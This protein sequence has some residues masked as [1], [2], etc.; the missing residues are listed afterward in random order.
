MKIDD[1]NKK[2]AKTRPRSGESLS[3]TLGG[4]LISRKNGKK[5]E[6]TTGQKL[7]KRNSGHGDP[8]QARTIKV[9][10]SRSLPAQNDFRSA[11]QFLA[12]LAIRRMRLQAQAMVPD[13]SRLAAAAPAKAKHGIMEFISGTF[14]QAP[15]EQSLH[16]IRLGFLARG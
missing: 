6:A 3:H 12:L 16:A 15:V 13:A 10:P 9:A 4:A 1:T 11:V 14:G 2:R 8:S 7:L 5:R